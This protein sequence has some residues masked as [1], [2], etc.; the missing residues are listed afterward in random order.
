MH[1]LFP[2]TPLFVYQPRVSFAYQLPPRLAVHGGFGAFND[3][4]PMQI[5]DL[6]SMNAPNDPTFVG[7]IGGQV[8]GI[9][10][11][12]GVPG[13]AIDAAVN[14]NQAFQATSAPAVRRAPGFSPALRPAL[15][16]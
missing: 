6:A 15:W 12:P 16:R 14:A 10:M 3:I 5:A 9:G 7:G 1:T 11:A 2:G 4:I 13:S 8:G